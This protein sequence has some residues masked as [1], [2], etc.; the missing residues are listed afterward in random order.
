LPVRTHKIEGSGAFQSSGQNLVGNSREISHH[1]SCITFD[2]EHPATHSVICQL[3][4]RSLIWMLFGNLILYYF[5]NPLDSL[6]GTGYSLKRF[7]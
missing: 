2:I 5:G 1:P 6:N 4:I 3:N 7:N